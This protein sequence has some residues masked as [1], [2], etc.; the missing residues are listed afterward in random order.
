VARRTF[1]GNPFFY[2][3]PY[4]RPS[5]D[6]PSP[7]LI[8]NPRGRLPMSHAPRAGNWA[9]GSDDRFRRGGLVFRF[10]PKTNASVQPRLPLFFDCCGFFPESASS[11][12]RSP[13]P[14]LSPS[15]G[16][17]AFLRPF[18]F[19]PRWDG[20]QTRTSSSRPRRLHLR[21]PHNL[22]PNK[23]FFDYVGCPLEGSGENFRPPSGLSFVP[24]PFFLLYVRC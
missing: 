19:P 13:P 20:Q 22:L 14:R 18:F 6:P 5:T 16:F 21:F 7:F 23:L 1:A 24:P 15:V 10:S 17:S 11:Q 8:S 2:P 3:F 9:G 4:F 12:L